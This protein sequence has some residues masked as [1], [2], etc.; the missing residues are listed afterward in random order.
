MSRLQSQRALRGFLTILGLVAVSAGLYAVVTGVSGMPGDIPAGVSVDSE[1]R[2]F[3]V[4][5]VAF[6]AVALWMAPRLESQRM[7]LRAWALTLFA[8]GLARVIGW[9]DEGRPDDLFMGLLI[10]ELVI[11][12]VIV[13]WQSRLRDASRR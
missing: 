4:F 12:L 11:P 2:F 7:L 8:A 1:L 5:Y 6:G 13:V 3:A 9:L 10:A